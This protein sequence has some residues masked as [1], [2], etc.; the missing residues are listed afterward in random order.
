MGLIDVFKKNKNGKE[1]PLT[2]D[3]KVIFVKKFLQTYGLL[4]E[5]YGDVAGDD[6][7]S[8]VGTPQY[9]LLMYLDF[10]YRFLTDE[11]FKR[12]YIKYGLKLRIDLQDFDLNPESLIKLAECYT[13]TRKLPPFGQEGLQRTWER[14]LEESYNQSIDS[15]RGAFYWWTDKIVVPLQLIDALEKKVEENITDET[16]MDEVSYQLSLNMSLTDFY[17]E[18]RNIE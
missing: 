6:L 2:T 14:T 3:E 9:T 15:Y 13:S 12:K 17:L 1:P 5:D 16:Y 11:S 8:L 4:P 18:L 7:A 10:L